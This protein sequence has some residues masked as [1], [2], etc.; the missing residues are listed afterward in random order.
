MDAALDNSLRLLQ[1]AVPAVLGVVAGRFG[2]FTDPRRA[3]EV[4]NRYALTFGFPA[5]VLRGVLS[6]SEVPSSP[7]F[8]LIWPVALAALLAVVRGLAPAADR[9]TLALV[10]SFGNVAYLGLPF[11]I[12]LLGPSIEG[13]ASLAVSVHVALSVSVGPFLLERWSGGTGTSLRTAAARVL[14][15]PLFWAPVLGLLA[16]AGPASLRTAVV[17]W[18]SP[19][20]SSAAPVAL[21][22]I[23]LY[24]FLE[25]HRLTAVD[26]SLVWHV[27]MRQLT[28]PVVV[29]ALAL[30]ASTLGLLSSRHAMLHVLLAC[31]PVAITTF[32]IADRAGTGQDHVARAVVWSSLLA[33]GLLPLWASL[34][35]SLWPGVVP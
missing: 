26:R 18:I 5:L 24:V 25:R 11:S 1:L 17:P 32:A 4:L 19:V 3:V 16:H 29:A 27:G 22:V 12:V 2:L 10:T 9:G 20:A 23:G 35:G 31:M 34:A 15:L 14:S 7:V 13:A 33:F 28:A 6:T 30:G 8:W 21:F